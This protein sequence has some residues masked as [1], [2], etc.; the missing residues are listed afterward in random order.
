MT[1]FEDMIIDFICIHIIVARVV[2]TS[3]LLEGRHHHQ[4]ALEEGGEGGQAGGHP[5][6]DR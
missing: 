5:P 1:T 4:Q 2:G 3:V 6:G